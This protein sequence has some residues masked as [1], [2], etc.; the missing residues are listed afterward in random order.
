MNKYLPEF[1][2]TILYNENIILNI[3]SFVQKNKIKKLI[4]KR[5]KICNNKHVVYIRLDSLLSCLS[6][7]N[8]IIIT[9]KCEKSKYSF[10]REV[11][12]GYSS[13]YFGAL[14]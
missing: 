3:R 5:K 9:N 13:H 11:V 12:Q 1:G 10:L 4:N 14:T 8:L 2:F 6:L 7:S